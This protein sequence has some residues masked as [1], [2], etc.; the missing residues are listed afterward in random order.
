VAGF[1]VPLG[2]DEEVSE[3]IEFVAGRIFAYHEAVRVGKKRLSA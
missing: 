3:S 1:F 2:R